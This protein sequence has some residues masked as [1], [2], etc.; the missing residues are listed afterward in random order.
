[1]NCQICG[2]NTEL[3]EHH[4]S[5]AERYGLFSI[6]IVLEV[7]M[8]C[9]HKIHKQEGFHDE[10]NPVELT[11]ESTGKYEDLVVGMIQDCD[12]IDSPISIDS[13]KK[14]RMY[15]ENGEWKIELVG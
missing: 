14:Y 7:C 1:M 6:E 15:D 13:E 3:L 8:D 2:E 11:P 4:V 5:Y 10:L 9:H 12:D